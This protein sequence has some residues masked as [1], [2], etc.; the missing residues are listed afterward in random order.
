MIFGLNID[1]QNSVDGVIGW[2]Y[3]I[4]TTTICGAAVTAA[5]C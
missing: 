4:Q 5:T 3:N 2:G 1:P